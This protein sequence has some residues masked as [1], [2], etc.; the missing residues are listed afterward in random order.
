MEVS[1][2][3]ARARGARGGPR[4]RGPKGHGCSEIKAM[5]RKHASSESNKSPP[6]KRAV[7]YTR[8]F[9]KQSCS[10]GGLVEVLLLYL[11]VVM[12]A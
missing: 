12:F 8:R 4:G 5:Y 10:Y 3:T 6:L 11:K 7:R 9:Q 2:R 1:G